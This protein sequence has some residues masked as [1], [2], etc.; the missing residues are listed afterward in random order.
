MIRE[1]HPG[2][3]LFSI[4][5][6]GSGSK[7]K[8]STVSRIHNTADKKRF[9]QRLRQLSHSLQIKTGLLTIGTLLCS[10]FQMQVG[11]QNSS[12]SK[13]CPDNSKFSFRFLY[14]LYVPILRVLRRSLCLFV[15][16]DIASICSVLFLR[17]LRRRSG[18]PHINLKGL[19]Q[20]IKI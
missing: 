20:K 16:L 12:H 13:M 14:P 2:S 18:F 5:D 1:F 3:R 10:C 19:P 6:H 8:K 17:V 7:G 4:L 15:L 9:D 11:P